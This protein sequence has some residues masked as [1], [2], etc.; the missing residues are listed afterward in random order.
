MMLLGERI[1]AETGV[2]WG[3]AYNWGHAYKMYE[4]VECPTAARKLA[5]RLANGPTL[6]CRKIKEMLRA[7]G[8]STLDEQLCMEAE[9]QITAFSAADC[10]EGVAAFVEKRDPACTGR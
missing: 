5:V 4:G 10:R 9:F 3:H 2:A 6:A 1:D 7:S 8:D